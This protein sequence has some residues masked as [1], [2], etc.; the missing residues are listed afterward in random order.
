MGNKWT[1]EIAKRGS[2]EKRRFLGP[3]QGQRG[4]MIQGNDAGVAS[5]QVAVYTRPRARTTSTCCLPPGGGVHPA[6]RAHYLNMLPSSRWR[7][8]ARPR[9]RTTSTSPRTTWCASSRGAQVSAGACVCACAVSRRTTSGRSSTCP[10]RA[11]CNPRGERV[12]GSSSL[13]DFRL[14]LI[15]LSLCFICFWF[16]SCKASLFTVTLI[17]FPF[18]F[19]LSLFP[20]VLIRA[21]GVHAR[22]RAHLGVQRVLVRREA[23][24]ESLQPAKYPNPLLPEQECYA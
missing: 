13:F 5:L 20:C 24:Q 19:L 17:P 1:G 14:S 21:L 9:A 16:V 18:P 11:Q 7:C 4:N 3:F 22:R 6:P 23:Q 15:S 10:H 8:T 12:R 2:V